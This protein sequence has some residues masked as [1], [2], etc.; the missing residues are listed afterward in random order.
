MSEKIA[1]PGKITLHPWPS[2]YCSFIPSLAL[3]LALLCFT[4]SAVAAPVSV[5]QNRPSETPLEL[6]AF[7]PEDEHKPLVL[8]ALP[9]APPEADLS[10]QGSVFIKQFRLTGNTV[11]TNAELDEIISPY[12]NRKITSGE[13]QAVR[14]AL[15]LFYVN[16]G[17][18][19]SGAII[20]DQ[21]L[22]DNIVTIEIIEGELSDIAIS[23]D[24]R[25]K[26]S[27][28]SKR[29]ELGAG[30]PLNI[31]QLGER[32]Q[33]LQQNPRIEQLNAT[34][35]PGAEPGESRLNVEV[36]EAQP[37]QLWIAADNHQ[38]PSVGGEEARIWGFHQDLTGYG[39]TLSFE[40]DKADGLDEWTVNYAIPVNRYDT[41]LGVYYDSIDSEVVEDPFDE[42]DIKSD[43]E[44][45][46]LFLTQPFHLS[47]NET[48]TLGL[49]LDLR[50]NKTYLLGQRFAFVP[51]TD[52]GKTKL[53]VIRFSQE[54]VNRGRNRVVAARSMFSTGI[55]AFDATVNGED[56]DGKF[57]SW[58]GQFQW[59]ERIGNSEAQV[60][61]R[62]DGQLA[63]H[64][65]P[66]MEQF[67]VG[68]SDTVR[69][70]R[71]NRLVSDEGFVASVEVR[72]PV[73]SHAASNTAIQLAPFLDF[74]S[75]SNRTGLDPQKDH[76]GSMGLGV[77]GTAFKRF[78]FS[79]YYGHAF[80]DF[81]NPDNDIQD[82]GF[83]FS[84]SARL[85]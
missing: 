40:Y 28:I 67:T 62:A 55:D 11:F 84:L 1:P 20:P 66:P 54:M 77:I 78:D 35:E 46:S 65:L 57:V 31:V 82:D 74:A 8:P 79:L 41:T 37:Y 68:G 60:I 75:V 83:S 61:F 22:T 14:Y 26:D 53:S 13:L 2:G 7:E 15:T 38:S 9:E 48:L 19:N 71:E 56:R 32:L 50:E 72:I 36:Q 30:P 10:R 81:D 63:N 70:Y 85:L 59:A 5:P 24:H 4:A 25:L 49:S 58:L 47:V 3:L 44:T 33:I 27:Y 6:P 21:E 80:Q 73:Y 45:I 76:I 64:G 12:E 69:G 52:N 23:G 18:I 51:G 29:I 39:D 34:L 16:H 17:Y 42:L 43:E